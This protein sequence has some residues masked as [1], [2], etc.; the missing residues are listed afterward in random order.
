MVKAAVVWVLWMQVTMTTTCTDLMRCFP[1]V[2]VAPV[3][4]SALTESSHAVCA[5]RQAFYEEWGSFTQAV[6]GGVFAVQTI[7]WCTL[8]QAEG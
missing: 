8:E 4:R 6:P 5:A 7:A 2:H 1:H 3:T